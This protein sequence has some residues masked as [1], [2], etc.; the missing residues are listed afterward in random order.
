[1]VTVVA[2][3]VVLVGAKLL[4]GSSTP[5][6]GGAPSTP[7]PAAVVAAVTSVPLAQQ[8]AAAQSTPVQA[9]TALKGAALTADGKPEILY[10]GAEFC[11]YCAAERWAVVS[12]LAHFGTWSGLG[13]TTSSASDSFP[14]TP[15]L[16]FHGAT[17]TSPYLTF[18]AV[19]E[20]TNQPCQPGSAGCSTNGYRTLDQATPGEEQL[21]QANDATGSIPFI[22]IGGSAYLVGSSYSPQV[23]AGQTVSD[24]A[25]RLQQPQTADAS[26]IDA[27]AAALTKAICRITGD[28][29][30]AACSAFAA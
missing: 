20:T 9:P 10:I 7:A 14:S 21:L 11:P 4:G 23:L 8:I 27:S 30:A 18:R 22:D 12:A 6:S 19:E 28:R 1:M 3:V 13:V 5:H 26:A 24:V 2:L 25:T 16:S 29:P 15:T 17:F